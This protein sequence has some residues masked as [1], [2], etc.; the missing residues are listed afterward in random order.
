MPT[1]QTTTYDLTTG[2]YLDIEPLLAL[3]SPTEV[4]FQGLYGADGRSTLSTGT[5]FEKKVEWLDEVLLTPRSTLAATITTGTAYI[6]VAADEQINFSTGDLLV[7]DDE[8][9]RVTGYGST[10][11]TL[12]VTRAY[13]SSTAVNHD[14]SVDV[15]TVGQA[16]AE[17][18][19][20]EDARFIDRSNRYNV[21]QI[22][23]PTAV[24]V[25][26][27]DNVVRK[28]GIEGTTEFQ[29]Q[30]A[31]RMREA[32]ISFEQAIAYG[33]RYE[34]TTTKIR[35]MGGLD[36]YITTNVDSTTT[37]LTESV[38]LDQLQACFNAGG[39]PDRA[40]LGSAQKRVASALATGVTI[41]IGRQDNG[42][43]QVV[44]FIDSD[45]GRISLLMN[46][47]I[48][49]S[50]L[51]LYNRDQATVLSLRPMVFE[52]LAKTGDSIKGQIVAE[53]TMRF[54]RE[55]HAAKFTALT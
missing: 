49:T 35:Q 11:D 10:T 7:V 13:S 18:S 44:D 53:K 34:S 41:Q 19:D 38:L 40:S 54:R 45:F 48:R 14:T 30:L 39:T 50:D 46:R 17:G 21:T 36:Y 16:L 4:P 25:S 52:P 28:Y 37:A 15:L 47:W 6:T 29:H 51:F 26:A 5:C 8:T 32:A 55:R 43:G 33:T 23:G 24:Q 22:F 20:P 31:N 42:R 2:L 3:L 1:G 27:S 9:L 12:T